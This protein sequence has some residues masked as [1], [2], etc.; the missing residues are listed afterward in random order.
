MSTRDDMYIEELEAALLKV[1]RV[2]VVSDDA[3]NPDEDAQKY[4]D[5]LLKKEAGE[6]RWSY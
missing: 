5:K 4:F 6:V 2:Y 3:W 1:I